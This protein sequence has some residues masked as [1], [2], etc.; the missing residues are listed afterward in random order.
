M[1]AFASVLLAGCAGLPFAG[2]G[3]LEIYL[4]RHAEKEPGNDPALTPDGKLRAKALAERLKNVDLTAIYSTDYARTRQTAG[5]VA[6]NSGIPVI[7]YDPQKLDEFA[8]QL[9]AQRGKVLVV[10]HSNTVPELVLALGGDGGTPIVE[11]TEYDR[12]YKLSVK[13]DTVTTDLQR[14]GVPSPQ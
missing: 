1:A 13:G 12:F 11:A 8:A 7:Y 10:G 14:Y 5:P 4:V 2:Q 3:D 9:R 6:L